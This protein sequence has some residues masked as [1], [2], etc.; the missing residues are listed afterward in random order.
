MAS[1]TSSAA[2]NSMSES[3]KLKRA[4]NDIR[5]EYGM[6]VDP[7]K[8]KLC[9]KLLS[10]RIFRIKQHIA[11]IKGN[12][13]ACPKSTDEDKAKCIAAIEAARN[14]KKLKKQH[15]EEVREEVQ[16]VD[17]EEMEDVVSNKRPRFLGPIDK[18]ASAISPD[19]SMD[20]SKRM[21][22]QN[23]SDAL[24]K[25]RTHN[26]HQFLARWV[27]EAGIPFYAFGND[28]FKRFIEAV[29]QFGP[30]YQPPSQYLLREPLLKEEVERTKKSLKKQE[31]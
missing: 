15:N 18:F 14:K 25:E 8:C 20:T 31:E 10:G 21:R 17:D 12:V 22:Q 9:E 4:S 6:L 27:Y 23:I 13:A 30:G 26:V 16:I 1:N 2:S 29:G 24:W 19:S 28:S 7:M 3:D 11:H 5:W